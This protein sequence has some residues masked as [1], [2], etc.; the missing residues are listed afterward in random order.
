MCR[1]A[2]M[3]DEA[4]DSSAADF[5]FHISIQRMRAMRRILVVLPTRRHQRSV[6]HRQPRAAVICSLRL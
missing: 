4:L 5:P 6:S 3:T 1:S 2:C